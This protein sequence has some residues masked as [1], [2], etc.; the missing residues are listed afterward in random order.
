ML[1][2]QGSDESH[3]GP[4]AESTS[5]LLCCLDTEAAREQEVR[6]CLAGAWKW[7]GEGLVLVPQTGEPKLINF[8]VTVEAHTV[9]VSVTVEGE[10]VLQQILHLRSICIANTGCEEI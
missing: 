4:T 1:L 7:E 8:L 10:G 5:W 3:S 9:G 6:E 2:S